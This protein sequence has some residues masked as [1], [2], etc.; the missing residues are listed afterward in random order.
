MTENIENIKIPDIVKTVLAEQEEFE[1]EVHLH[2]EGAT[3]GSDLYSCAKVKARQLAGLRAPPKT[4]LKAEVGAMTVGKLDHEIVQDMVLD[5]LHF[6]W[7]PYVFTAVKE[8][9]EPYEFI[10]N[11]RVESPIDIALLSPPGG[12]WVDWQFRNKSRKILMRHP[13]AKY[14]KI[15]DLK[16]VNSMGFW[17]HQGDTEISPGYKGQMH[18]Y[19]FQTRGAGDLQKITIVFINK[20]T[21]QMYEVVVEWDQ[22]FWD[23]LVARNTRIQEA[24][25]QLKRDEI[26]EYKPEDLFMLDADM[27]WRCAFCAYS[28]CKE[29]ISEKSKP[30]LE[31]IRPCDEAVKEVLKQAYDK[32]TKGS[33]WKRGRAIVDIEKIAGETMI[34]INTTNRR[35]KEKG[36]PFE[37]YEDTI[38]YAYKNF[39]ELD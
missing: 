29:I 10:P 28:V 6:S 37:T 25:E 5:N 12:Q 16:T 18:G 3:G 23:E 9:Y 11:W 21:F 2:Q 26:P 39:E 38:Y 34:S 13:G 1:R 14:L 17:S 30:R 33:R 22:I 20:E 32:F 4:G 27:N 36:E 15:W 35:K 31:L 7:D 24:A 8:I 19:M